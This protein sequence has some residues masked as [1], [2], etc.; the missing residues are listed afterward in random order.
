MKRKISGMLV[1]EEIDQAEILKNDK[2]LRTIQ[3]FTDKGGLIRMETRVF[4]REDRKTLHSGTGGQ[5]WKLRERYWPHNARRTVAL[6]LVKIMLE[7]V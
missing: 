7:T 1:P 6:S 4:N 5:S 2:R 3:P